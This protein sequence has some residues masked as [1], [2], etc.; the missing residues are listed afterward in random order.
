MIRRPPRSTLFPY[1]TLFRSLLTTPEAA[2]LLTALGAYADALPDDGRTRGQKMAD[3]LL[4][5]VLRPGES[6]LPPVQIVLSVVAPVGAL[7]GG[8]QPGEIDG[9]VV[10]AEVVRAL[11]AAL[12]GT[13]VATGEDAAATTEDATAPVE[14][15]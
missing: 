11:L 7:L 8:D 1:T 5:L 15:A 13:Q 6:G 10:P 12:T 2:A 3:C 14:D 9:H 4:D